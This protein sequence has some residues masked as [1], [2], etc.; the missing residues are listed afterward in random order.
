[1]DELRIATRKSRLALWQANFI[2]TEL[3]R[4]HRGLRVELVGMTTE[5]DRRLDAHLGTVGGKGLFI[6]ELEAALLRGAADLAVHSMK[7]V[8]AVVDPR[9]TLAAIGYREDARDAWISPH[10][11]FDS[12]PR[13]ATV[14]SSSLRRQAQLLAARPD[15]RVVPLRGNVDTRLRKLE[16]GELDAVVLA[17]A[18]L[19]RLGWAHRITETLSI[20]RCLPAPGQGALGIECLAGTA[21]I[22]EL[23]E[24]LNDLR[25][26]QC[27]Q[28]E[29]GVSAALG[30]DCNMPLGAYAA[31]AA[32]GLHLRA[33]LASPDGRMLLC[34]AATH[35][36]AHSAV[37]GVVQDL[38]RQGADR[39][40]AAARPPH[41]QP[42]VAP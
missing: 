7:D 40:L 41:E 4:H 5:G 8:P 37:A 16:R 32:G 1:M 28:A 38:R 22:Q 39:L 3:Q 17:T 36:E 34:A 15:L 10:G 35:R 30:A 18:G 20:E 29:R 19:A 33:L 6:K 31:P 2:K 11:A 25:V 23:L 13:G 21:H 26:A 12:V 14:G 9:F 42:E 24:P 27:V